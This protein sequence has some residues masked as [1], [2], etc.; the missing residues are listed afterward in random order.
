MSW[1]KDPSDSNCD[2][3]LRAS[4]GIGATEAGSGVADLIITSGRELMRLQ[5]RMTGKHSH[6]ENVLSAAL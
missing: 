2:R 4:T 3:V 1:W 5:R 6:S